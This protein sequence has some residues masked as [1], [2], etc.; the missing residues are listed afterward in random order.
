VR[1]SRDVVVTSW[2]PDGYRL[3]G[4]HFLKSFHRH[5][6]E[7]WDRLVLYA[8]APMV[9]PK[10]TV[11]YT[12][13][14]PEWAELSAR[15]KSDPS[16]HGWATPDYPR[17][18]HHSYVWDAARFAVKVFVWRDAAVKLGRGTLT[19]LDGDTRTKG[20]VTREWPRSLLGRADVAYLGRGPMH[21]ETGYVG[22]RI[23][24][25]LPLLDW[26]CDAYLSERF[27]TMT[28]GWTDCHILRAG[29]KAVPVRSVDLTRGRY[30]GDSNIWPSSP[31][32]SRLDHAKGVQRKRESDATT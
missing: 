12:G 7:A 20:E 16:V 3:Y 15:W 23:P 8:D 14:I 2:S 26:C 11:R 10:L 24:Q 25:A 31:L 18:K 27:R 6:D 19:W 9:H 30:S 5:W 13:D 29:L 28:D 4:K 17:S 21:P 1:V 22:F 32:A